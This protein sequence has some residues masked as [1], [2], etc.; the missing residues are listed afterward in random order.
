MQ[1]LA[2]S[3]D[4]EGNRF[5][6]G[7]A[8]VNERVGAAYIYEL[9]DDGSYGL[10]TSITPSDSAMRFGLTTAISGDRVAIGAPQTSNAQGQVYIY[11]L[12]D[13]NETIIQYSGQ[14]TEMYNYGKT[15][16]LFGNILIVGA[17]DGD[18]E[19]VLIYEFH[20]GNWD[21]VV[22]LSSPQTYSPGVATDGSTIVLGTLNQALNL[23]GAFVY[24]LGPPV[25]TSPASTETEGDTIISETRPSTEME[26]DNGKAP[27]GDTE[28]EVGIEDEAGTGAGSNQSDTEIQTG[29][30]DE[31]SKIPSVSTKT[32]SNNGP[33]NSPT[34]AQ[35][36]ACTPFGSLLNVMYLASFIA[37]FVV[38]NF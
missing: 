5:I 34:S 33:T 29:I 16:D 14:G 15:L 10:L 28:G 18:Y 11:R 20:E 3:V 22:D 35:S 1:I 19:H 27:E 6:V 23:G 31:P 21:L 32:E 4:M 25:A 36:S 7:A 2:S 37:H 38:Q 30:L 24:G 17:W 26:G 8:G 12:P 9:S 13:L